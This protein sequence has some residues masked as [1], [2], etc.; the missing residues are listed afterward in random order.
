MPVFRSGRGNA[1]PW[2]EMT[3]FEILTLHADESV[4]LRRF[5]EKEK[6]FICE[7]S[8]RVLRGG[9]KVLAGSGEILS[10][11]SP[12]GRFHVWTDKESATLVRVGGHW[13]EQIGGAGVFTLKQSLS[14]R[15]D[16]DPTP[17]PRN[18]EFDNHYHDFDEYW[19]LVK[20]RG[21]I[22]T[23]G[24]PYD[25]GPGDCVATGRGHHHDFPVVEEPITGVYFETTLEG[26]KRLGHLWEHKHGP[27]EPAWD[28]V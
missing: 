1:P 16:G 8:C 26:R 25:V 21:K 14:P 15:N 23:E 24:Q 5:G 12:D 3:D 6:L 4:A 18:T 7:G 17:Y 27:P 28:R 11:D 22:R 19:I 2:C 13:G 9:E 10:L 20:G